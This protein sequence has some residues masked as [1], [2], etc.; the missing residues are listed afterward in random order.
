MAHGH[1]PHASLVTATPPPLRVLALATPT[2]APGFAVEPCA[3]CSEAIERLAGD[4]G[5]DA[6]M[7]DGDH[8]AC[9]ADEGG[10]IAERAVGC[11]IGRR[12]RTLARSSHSIAPGSGLPNRQQLAE[13]LSRLLALREREPVPMAVL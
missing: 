11:A 2:S 10:A 4:A 3:S 8:N 12:R 1:R 13:H 6:V 5:F 7:V 9:L